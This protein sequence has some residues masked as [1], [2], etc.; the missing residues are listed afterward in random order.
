MRGRDLFAIARPFLLVVNAALRLVP[1]RLCSTML[2]LARHAPTKGGLLVRY[3]L[4]SRLARACGDNVAIFEGVYLFH[5]DRMEIGAN[6]S[7]HPMCYLDGSGGLR[8]GSD[9]SIAH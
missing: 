1:S 9:V 7:I 2:T 4:V 6:V 3:I 8:I 5:V